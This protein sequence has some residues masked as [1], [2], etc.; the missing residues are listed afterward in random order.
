MFEG[1]LGWPGKAIPRRWWGGIGASVRLIGADG[2]C[3][4]VSA[5]P[6]LFFAHRDALFPA[7][8]ALEWFDLGL[9]VMRTFILGVCVFEI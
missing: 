7:A 1:L 3:H 4:L 9:K 5:L 2:D 6:Q 8:S